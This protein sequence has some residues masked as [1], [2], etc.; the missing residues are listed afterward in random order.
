MTPPGASSSI[1]CFF[2]SS[3]TYKQVKTA[4]LRQPQLEG[5]VVGAGGDQLPVR[6]HVHAH[7]LP[8]VSRQRL[9]R[10]PAR[11]TPDLRRVVVRPRQ[12]EV[13]V[14]GCKSSDRLG[15]RPGANRRRDKRGRLRWKRTADRRFWWA[16]MVYRHFLFL[17]SHTL[18][19]LSPL[20][21]AR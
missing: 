19:E 18:Q 10:R 12:Q 2:I 14:R 16:G 17:S 9:Q 15:S 6:G 7:H 8:L 3:T 13:A 4:S 11:V 21:V 20:P 1:R 5:A